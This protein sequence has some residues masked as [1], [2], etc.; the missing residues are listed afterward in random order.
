MKFPRAFVRAAGL[1]TVL[2]SCVV[3][4]ARA[5]ATDNYPDSHAH[6][7]FGL[8][9]HQSQSFSPPSTLRFGTHRHQ[10][11]RHYTDLIHLHAQLTEAATFESGTSASHIFPV[12]RNLLPAFDAAAEEEEEEEEEATRVQQS[13]S[14]SMRPG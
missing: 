12:R 1:A 8:Q 2:P 14:Q 11:F 6:T 10:S 4:R 7:G 13:M 3:P 5:D 9:R